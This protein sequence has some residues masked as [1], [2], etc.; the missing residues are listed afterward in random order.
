VLLPVDKTIPPLTSD[1]LSP[2]LTL[3]F[4]V[5]KDDEDPVEKVILFCISFK[6][7]EVAIKVLSVANNFNT[8]SF[9]VEEASSNT[10]ED[11]LRLDNCTEGPK[12]DL[13]DPT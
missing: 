8:P 5:E 3:I 2:V 13:L 4:P 9:V 1:K 7:V 6:E 11:P 10:D 12:L